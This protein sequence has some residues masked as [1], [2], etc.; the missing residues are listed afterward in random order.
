MNI[1]TRKLTLT[2]PSTLDDEGRTVQ[3][4]LATD[5][6]VR[7]Y[8]AR[9]GPIDEVLLMS[10]AT[11]PAQVP[12]L[13]SH[14][15]GRVQDVLGSVTDIEA[16]GRALVGRLRF[17]ATASQAWNLVKEGHLTDVSVGYTVER[18]E[19]IPAGESREYEGRTIAG[20][21]QIA[22]AWQLR[23]LSLTP[24]GADAQ[25]KIR[26]KEEH[27]MEIQSD[28]Q[29]ERQ[30]AAAIMSMGAEFG[31]TD[32]ARAAIESGSTLETFQNEVLAKV[33]ADRQAAPSARVESGL[34][35][36]E[37]FR[38]AAVD[39]VL[40]R[41]GLTQ[42]ETTELTGLSMVELSRECLRRAGHRAHGDAMDVTGRAMTSSDLPNILIN[43]ASKQLLKGFDEAEETWS[44]W[45]GQ[46]SVPDF[47]LA[48]IVKLSEFSGL[49]EIAEHAEYT[50]GIVDD[51]KEQVQ[52]ATYGKIFMITRKALI[53][54]D[55][56]AL[57]EIPRLQGEA[58][59][60]LVGD[61]AYAVLTGNPTMSD[62]TVLFHSDHAN[63]G[64]PG[65]PAIGTV[66][67]AVKLMKLQK[68]L[69]GEAYLNLRP[70]FFLAP[71][72][73]EGT[74][75]QLFRS[76]LEGTQTNPNLINPYAGN[77]FTRV[78]DAR[79]DADDTG[80]W[81]LAGPKGKA[82][83]IYFLQGQ[84]KPYLERRDG[85]NIDGMEFKVRIE[86]AAKAVDWR[87]LV[88]NAGA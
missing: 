65:A 45:C 24:I 50:H 15:R 71:V 10:G 47:K 7:I 39:A 12:L 1:S 82:V 86:A 57:T 43:S 30:R 20:P 58:A 29:A 32:A 80:E 8:D 81:Y 63:V 27:Y 35:D 2:S 67:E 66:A 72:A 44:T 88:Y 42:G 4:V 79:L 5:D 21:V 26:S 49:E 52:V 56:A 25:A 83:N 75:E 84:S 41:A 11:V 19:W 40:T 48:S 9:R 23:E 78:Y 17:S 53:N 55:L 59:A 54:D 85:F 18:S 33:R 28:L 51:A 76:T 31:M 14:A 13:N 68:G 22:T 87:A 36:G 73:L 3:A 64:T 37:K 38:S 62:G 70:H 69:Q 6:P 77:Y 46:G 74:S 16:E 61:L 60:R 34:T